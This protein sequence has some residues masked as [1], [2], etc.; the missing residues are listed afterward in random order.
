M[1]P[2]LILGAG[3]FALEA[4]DIAEQTGGFQVEGFL[5]G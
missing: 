3:A 5:S 1:K 2:L 4:L